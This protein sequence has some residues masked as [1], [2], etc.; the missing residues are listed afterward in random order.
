MGEIPGVRRD[1]IYGGE[2]KI[3]REMFQIPVGHADE[4]DKMRIM[5]SR[6]LN[7]KKLSRR[8]MCLPPLQLRKL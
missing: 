6:L 5:P 2:C 8:F 7:A 3:Q 4:Q 1:E